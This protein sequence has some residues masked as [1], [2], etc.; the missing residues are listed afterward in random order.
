MVLGY[1]GPNPRRDLAKPWTL[2]KPIVV[3]AGQQIEIK[4]PLPAEE[5]RAYMRALE[6][7]TRLRGKPLDRDRFFT[8]SFSIETITGLIEKLDSVVNGTFQANVS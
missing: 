2:D 7:S 5:M 8:E 6:A 1:W 3:E 4:Y